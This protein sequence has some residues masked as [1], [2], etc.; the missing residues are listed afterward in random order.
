MV[1][2]VNKTLLKNVIRH[3]DA[4]NKVVEE[5]EMWKQHR[6]MKEPIFQRRENSFLKDRGADM[7]NEFPS[8]SQRRAH[9][10]DEPSSTYWMKKLYKAEETDK[11]RWGHSGFKELYPE[12]FHSSDSSSSEESTKYN[13]RKRSREREKKKQRSRK[14][15]LSDSESSDSDDSD[16]DERQT[17]K[18]KKSHKHKE[19]KKK[20]KK[21]KKLKKRKYRE[22]SDSTSS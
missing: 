13:H 4:H 3:T 19:K 8:R 16:S 2:V 7:R 11:D 18:R 5:E 1:S 10:D 6:K 20:S 14:R 15:H 9:M 22:E 21:K 17:K 12:K